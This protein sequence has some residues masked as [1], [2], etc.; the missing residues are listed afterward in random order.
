MAEGRKHG[1]HRRAGVILMEVV[2]ALTIFCLTAGIVLSGMSASFDAAKQVFFG[3][4]AADLAVTKMSV[5]RLEE[6]EM[7]NTG[8]NEY[9]EED[10]ANWTWEIAVEMQEP[11]TLAEEQ[12]AR[13]EVIIRNSETGYVHRLVSLL[14][15]ALAEV[16]VET[17]FE[18]PME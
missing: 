16:E 12:E 17:E 13:V 3:A 18:V 8:P 15:G 9:E 4:K 10:L 1:C 11:Y 6:V 5:I 2:L 7:A 14:P